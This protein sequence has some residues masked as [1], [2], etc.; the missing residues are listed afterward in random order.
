MRPLLAPTPFGGSHAY[1]PQSG[2]Q[3]GAA[4]GGRRRRGARQALA[5]AFPGRAVVQLD[6]DRLMGGGGGVHC[7]TM[8]QPDAG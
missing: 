3:S 2:A 8:Q 7:S 5:A 4:I 1:Q 6:V